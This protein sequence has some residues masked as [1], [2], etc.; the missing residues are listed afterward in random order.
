[1]VHCILQAKTSRTP[2]APA[3]NTRAQSK[4]LM[5]KTTHLEFHSY[6][7]CSLQEDIKSI[8]F[9]V[10]KKPDEDCLIRK[11][12]AIECKAVLLIGPQNA[13]DYCTTLDVVG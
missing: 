10:K 6:T 2:A 5:I 1:M 3:T 11:Q 8:G 12:F 13:S 4:L 7:Y 9:W